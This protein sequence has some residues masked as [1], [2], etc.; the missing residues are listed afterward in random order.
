MEKWLNKKVRYTTT[1]FVGKCTAVALYSTGKIS[2]LLEANDTTGRPIEYWITS[3][4]AKIIG[5]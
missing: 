4:Y 2:L 3:E 5:E 1:G